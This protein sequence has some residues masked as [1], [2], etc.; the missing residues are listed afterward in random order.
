MH[1]CSNIYSI[2][3]FFKFEYGVVAEWLCAWAGYQPGEGS[4]PRHVVE[5]L[6]PGRVGVGLT[7]QPVKTIRVTKAPTMSVAYASAGSQKGFLERERETR[8]KIFLFYSQLGIWLQ[9]YEFSESS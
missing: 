6:I 5:L 9:T 3:S 2:I 7:T 1:I 4:S 8:L